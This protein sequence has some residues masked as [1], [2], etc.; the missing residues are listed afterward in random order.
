MFYKFIISFMDEGVI[1]TYTETKRLPDE[2][3]GY[4][5]FQN[6]CKKFGTGPYYYLCSWGVL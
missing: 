4:G 6:L 1:N 5:H 3:A 2:T